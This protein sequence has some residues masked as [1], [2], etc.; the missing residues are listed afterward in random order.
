M[1][2]RKWIWIYSKNTNS[3]RLDIRIFLVCLAR[4]L[5]IVCCNITLATL[6]FPPRMKWKLNKDGMRTN[7]HGN[8]VPRLMATQQCWGISQVTRFWTDFLCSFRFRSFEASRL[9]F[10]VGFA[11]AS[12]A[13]RDERDERDETGMRNPSQSTNLV[14]EFLDIQPFQ[15]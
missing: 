6:D 7:H 13:S 10:V 9:R 8:V 14:L 2:L 1:P 5:Q 4:Q 3:I 11:N 15:A 12:S